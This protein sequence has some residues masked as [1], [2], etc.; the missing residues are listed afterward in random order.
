MVV[1]KMYVRVL[2]EF[3]FSHAFKLEFSAIKILEGCGI[4]FAGMWGQIRWDVG[5]DSLGCGVGLYR[6]WGRIV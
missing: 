2:F 4:G 3:T 1:Y 5:S 6:M